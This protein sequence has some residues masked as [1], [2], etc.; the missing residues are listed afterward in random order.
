MSDYR[1]IKIDNEN[2]VIGSNLFDTSGQ[3]VTFSGVTLSNGNVLTGVDSFVT[4][5]TMNGNSLELSRNQGLGLLSIDMSQFNDNTDRFVTGSTFNNTTYDLTLHR[6]GGLGDIISNLSVLA[7]DIFV[8]SGEYNM[9]TGVVTYTTN[10]GTTFEVSGFTTG[11]TDTYTSAANLNGNTIQFDSNLLG[12]NLYNVDLTPIL[13]GFT[14]TDYYVTGATM[15]SNTLELSRNGLANVTVDLSQFVNTDTNYYVTG[16]TLNGTI[17]ETTRS[18]GLSTLSTELSGLTNGLGASIALQWKF[19]TATTSSDPG[20]KKL[21]FDDSTL[22]SVTEVYFNDQTNT[23]FDSSTILDNLDVGDSIYIQQSNDATKYGLFTVNTT[24]TDEIGWWT[25]PVTYLDGGI[26]VP[27]NNAITSVVL[28]S[29]PHSTSNYYVTGGTVSGTDLLL[30]RNGGLNNVTI[31]TSA[32]FD[33]TNYY[34]TGSTLNGNTLELGR[35]GGLTTLTTDLSQ[36]IDNTDNF[37]TGGTMVGNTLVLNRT[38]SLSAVTVDLSQFDVAANDTHV[39]GF[40]Y[41]NTNILTLGRNQGL[42]D[43]NV[44]IEVV[45]GLTVNGTLNT[46]VI[47]FNTSYTGNTI[48]DGRMYWD[49]NNGTLS[50]GM[51]GGNV[52]QQIGQESYYYIKNQSGATINNGKVVRASGTL[53]SSGRILGEYMIADGTIPP[54]YT[55]GIATEDIVDGS[56]GY[57]TEFGL[58]RGIDTTGTPYGETWNDGDV[59]WVSTT[60]EGG[61]TNVQPT[62][63]NYNIEMAIVIDSDSNGS[64]FVRPNRYPHFHDLQEANW[65][66]G[67]ENNLD[68]IQ[69]NGTTNSFNLTNTPTFNSVSASTFYGDGSNLIGISSTDNYVTGGTMVG[70]T[71]VL[72]RTDA[73]SAV[74]VDLTDV[75]SASISVDL[76]SWTSSGSTYF[77]DFTH[78]LNTK[79]L[80][81]ETYDINNDKIIGVDNVE[82][83]NNDTIRV[84]ITDN[85]SSIRTTV[86][87][88]NVTSVSGETNTASNIGSGVGVYKTKNAYNLEFKSLSNTDGKLNISGTTTEINIDLSDGVVITNNVVVSGNYTAS[89]GDHIFATGGVTGITISLPP[90]VANSGEINVKKVD[91]GVGYVT[92]DGDGSD[93]ID[94]ELTVEL[95]EQMESFTLFPSTNG[96]YII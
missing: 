96:W 39:T 78:S 41:N 58:V 77:S 54:K 70:K 19:S 61:L 5:A 48:V 81:V 90:L 73:L 6:S 38:N 72:N 30:S 33:N 22:A 10:S 14:S 9:S 63:P 13:S 26:S 1:I 4:G 68:V 67:S 82:F 75:V 85:T 64:L 71:L 45:S 28:F 57:V 84:F 93:T 34:V 47:D 89:F 60:I 86:I 50:L 43:L 66:G 23:G 49:T 3:T 44:T 87:G 37:V 7:S 40:T 46:D 56:D 79:D 95:I 11:M 83:I 52:L 16:Q 74:T 29:G 18:G 91:S 80:L 88:G 31:D 21:S 15:N 27:S 2:G 25:V 94:D 36:F 17:L 65:T 51:E 92:I 76:T 55:L 62:V 69:W 12:T 53:G 20:S 42:S 24:P 59:L 8:L 32:Y 35:S